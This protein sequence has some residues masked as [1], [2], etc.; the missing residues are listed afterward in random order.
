M[1]YEC[2]ARPWVAIR[3]SAS[4]VELPRPYTAGMGR[5]KT[6]LWVSIAFALLTAALR[7]LAVPIDPM[8]AV[9][10]FKHRTEPA[11]GVLRDVGELVPGRM[12]H[13][14]DDPAKVLAAIPGKKTRVGGQTEIMLPDGASAELVE[15]NSGTGQPV[16]CTLLLFDDRRHWYQRSWSTLRSRL[17]F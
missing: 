12:Y 2:S 4:G 3:V 17:G 14:E 1:G 8:A 9:L 15:W 6:F 5:R 13:F 10:R 7:L 16:T 11:T